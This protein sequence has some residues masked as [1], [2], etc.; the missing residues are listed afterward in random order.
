MTYLI[1][2]YSAS[3][4]LFPPSRRWQ[5]DT[6]LTS[7]GSRYVCFS[8]RNDRLVPPTFERNHRLHRKQMNGYRETDSMKESW[9]SRK[10][11][12]TQTTGLQ[13]CRFEW[14][15]SNFSNVVLVD[16]VLTQ[17][18]LKWEWNHWITLLD[19]VLKFCWSS[20]ILCAVSGLEPSY[21]GLNMFFILSFCLEMT[22]GWCFRVSG[23][24]D[25]LLCPE[26]RKF[27]SPAPNGRLAFRKAMKS[28]NVAAR[29]LEYLINQQIIIE[30]LVLLSN[31]EVT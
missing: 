1:K 11:E 5:E 7:D 15:Q 10:T 9:M 20:R 19:W 26:T 31:Y 23:L 24:P 14:M 29:L 25:L 22:L 30:E 4:C 17:D 3:S 8:D 12:N 2:T 28:T 6:S 21:L 18:C 16:P 27:W 13:C